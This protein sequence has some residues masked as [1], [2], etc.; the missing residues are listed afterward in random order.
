MKCLLVLLRHGEST[1][2]AKNVFTGW[3]DV[4]LSKKGIQQ[5][6][7]A[8]VSIKDIMI[9]QVYTSNLIRAQTT[10]FLAMASQTSGRFCNRRQFLERQHASWAEIYEESLK[11]EQVPIFTAWELNERMY[12][13]LQGKNKKEAALQFGDDQIQRW[14]RSFSEAPP[15]GE[16]LEQTA[17]R[18]IPYFR[19]T[20][21]LRWTKAI[22]CLFVRMAIH[23]DRSLWILKNSL[24]KKFVNLRCLLG[25]RVFMNTQ[26]D[27]LLSKKARHDRVC[28]IF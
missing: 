16:S 1:L 26:M 18:T 2:N 15:E 10:A 28:T 24:Q 20:L 3:I 19:S 6:L 23:C 17:K 9:D 8:G 25:Y 11:A 22:M 4:P 14:R 5:A 27:A 21:L 12:G 7:D 13:K